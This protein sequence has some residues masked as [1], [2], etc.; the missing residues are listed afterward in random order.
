MKPYMFKESITTITLEKIGEKT[1]K[2]RIF[3]KTKQR[4]TCLHFIL[5]NGMQL[6]SMIVFKG[7]PKNTLE[8]RPNKL[9]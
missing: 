1:I 9:K 8:H 2:I 7:V 4:N 6:P 5:A 3:S